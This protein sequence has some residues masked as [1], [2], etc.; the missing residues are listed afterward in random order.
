MKQENAL[1]R[2]TRSP[3][4][5]YDC[6][7]EPWE[8]LPKIRGAPGGH[9][10]G[11]STK[12][13]HTGK[14]NGACYECRMRYQGHEGPRLGKYANHPHFA[15]LLAPDEHPLM[16]GFGRGHRQGC[17]IADGH[18]DG[19]VKNCRRCQASAPVKEQSRY[20]GLKHR[21]GISKADY[22][23]LLAKQEGACGICHKPPPENQYLHV[24]H[25]HK[26][27]RIR[28]LLCKSCNMGLG[29]L[30]DD[31]LLLHSAIRYLSD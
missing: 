14:P 7:L 27:G 13:G 17:Q 25:D 2:L 18:D 20:F 1:A 4:L 10:L 9:R 21:H 30:G 26:T 8:H 16:K 28:G 23:T 31:A 15:C 22:E 5:H 29:I 12:P 6:S 3:E 11:C 24:D 19:W